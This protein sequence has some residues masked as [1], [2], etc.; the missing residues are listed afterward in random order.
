MP[1]K[2]E[3]SRAVPPDLGPAEAKA[4]EYL[5]SHREDA[6]FLGIGSLA[7]AA[8][9]SEATLSRLVRKLGF[10][11][12]AEYQD[13][14]QRQVRERL[15]PRA[16]TS[17]TL[18][19][20]AGRA[21]YL[22]SVFRAEAERLMD[23]ADI[24]DEP[25]FERAAGEIARA[26]RVFIAGLGVSRSLCS[27]LAFR[28]TRFGLQAEQVPDAGSLERAI[29]IGRGDVALAVGFVRMHA[30][31]VSFLE[32]SASRGAMTI[33]ITEGPTTPLGRR[34][35]I[36]LAAPRGPV[37][38]LGSLALPMI[39]ANAVAIRAAQLSKDRVNAAMRGLE[40]MEGF[41]R[42]ALALSLSQATPKR[43]GETGP[44]KRGSGDMH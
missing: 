40:R 22:G 5:E 21:E 24:V 34:A 9:V 31:T 12:F 7:K 4:A 30:E 38:E 43:R 37:A 6:A 3:R 28:L 23:M 41:Y 39:V 18:N 1:D 42:E 10:A 32:W 27:F 20:E 44:S 2:R 25:A 26:R 29:G 33:A 11:R 19:H 14:L 13:S 36:V 17:R 16:K 8:K 15:T 35:E